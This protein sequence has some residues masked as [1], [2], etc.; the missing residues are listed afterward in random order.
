MTNI[1]NRS[2]YGNLSCL[3]AVFKSRFTKVNDTLKA[4]DLKYSKRYK[5]NAVDICYG[6][7]RFP[8]ALIK[9]IGREYYCPFLKSRTDKRVCEWVH[10]E[11]HD[12]QKSKPV[13][14]TALMLE[15]F[16]LTRNNY[17]ENTGVLIDMKWTAKADEIFNYKWGD[18]ELN[19]YFL[20]HLLGY[21]P[22][23]NLINILNTYKK[24]EFNRNELYPFLII[25]P[26]N[27]PIRVL[28][29][30]GESYEL[31]IWDGNTSYDAVTRSTATLLSL[32]AQTGS[33]APK[34]MKNLSILNP[35]DY[36][37]W[38]TTSTQ[39]GQT[40]FPAKWVIQKDVVKQYC[41]NKFNLHNGISYIHFIPKATDRNKQNKCEKCNI[42]FLNKARIKYSSISQ[43]RKLL[44]IVALKMAYEKKKKN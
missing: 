31:S 9:R 11:N 35:I 40:S 2:Q 37:N 18:Q 17:N 5:S 4:K 8:E 14:Q 25:Q 26:T 33:I 32:L 3:F 21:G 27:D 12:T 19:E 22:I 29:D 16:N 20:H 13:G 30:C 10:A 6:H 39:E 15:L 36:S 41:N 23:I 38:L 28:C 34:K 43:N 42:N 44:L 1:P 7:K 24:K